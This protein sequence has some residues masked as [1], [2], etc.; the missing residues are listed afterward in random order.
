[1]AVTGPSEAQVMPS[2]RGT[3]A[4]RA[5]TLLIVIAPPAA[6]VLAICLLWGRAVTLPDLLVAGVL[7][8]VT[9][10]GI[11]IGYH[12]LFTHSSFVARRPLKIALASAGSMAI[13]GSPIGWVAN[14]RRHHRFSDRPGDPH[15][16]WR[17]GRGAF[18]QLRGLYWAHLGWLFSTDTT[19]SERYAAD[20]LDDR[21]LI[22]IGRLFPVFAVASLLLPAAIGWA[23]T[24]TWLGAC[25][26]FIWGG[27]VRVA[28]LHHVTWSV[29]SVCHM[30]GAK[31]FPTKDRS[32]NFAPLAILSFG[33]SWH[34]FHH[35][36]PRSARH[37]VLAHQTDSAAA[38]IR[39]FERANWVTNVRWPTAAQIAAARGRRG[40][41]IAELDTSDS[42]RSRQVRSGQCLTRSPARGGLHEP[43]T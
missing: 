43:R 36:S 12:R 23:Y 14:H 35:A 19:R 37:G 38:I 27:L 13:E 28:L 42:T 1:M 33:E 4:S 31:P 7:Y 40:A 3:S 6:A 32:T 34:S 30:F 5:I 41:S 20:L 39:L 2:R 17:F 10:H 25:T 24:G 11:A 22:V 29:N 8:A 15:S 9:G 26:G 18:P 16:P 21:D